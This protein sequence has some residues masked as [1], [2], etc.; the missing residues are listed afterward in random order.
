MIMIELI[1]MMHIDA[2]C[3]TW[4]TWLVKSCV[5][6]L[7]VRRLSWRC[8]FVSIPDNDGYYYDYNDDDYNNYNDYEYDNDN[9]DS[10]G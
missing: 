7:I 10:D 5:W 2:A 8:S 3:D 4:Y 1:L 9:E 6:I